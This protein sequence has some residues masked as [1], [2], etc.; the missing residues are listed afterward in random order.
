MRSDTSSHAHLDHLPGPL[1]G[2]VRP[3]R[4][5][6]LLHNHFQHRRPQVEGLAQ[7]VHQHLLHRAADLRV[8]QAI[9]RLPLELGLP[10]PHCGTQ[11][12]VCCL[13]HAFKPHGRHHSV[14][15]DMAG[16]QAMAR[17]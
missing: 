10:H 1:G 5:L 15:A 4:T 13:M 12:V 14:L 9:L 2:L 6:P 7:P 3:H 16:R 8:G 11:H 17:T